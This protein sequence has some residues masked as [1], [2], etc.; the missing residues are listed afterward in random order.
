M[1]LP[2]M[3]SIVSG[4]IVR[5]WIKKRK[6]RLKANGIF[7]GIIEKRVRC[8]KELTKAQK[9]HNRLVA[10]IRAVVE[11]PFA[12]MKN[13][14]YVRTRYRGMRRNA[15]DF[16]LHVIAYDWKRSFSL[17]AIAA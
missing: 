14:G 2:R 5:I 1:S 16:G 15:L 3:R 10:G 7:C 8:Q 17:V 6:A 9:R 4:L 12:W 11:H 13:A